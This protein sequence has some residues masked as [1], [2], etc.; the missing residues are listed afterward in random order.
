MLTTII[1]CAI[2]AV[3]GVIIGY[4]KGYADGNDDMNLIDNYMG[5]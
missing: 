5:D 1:L 2:S 4:S 3:S